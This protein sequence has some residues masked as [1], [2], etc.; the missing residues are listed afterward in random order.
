MSRPGS[1]I[2][3]MIPHRILH[4]L[5]DVH[6]LS[7]R[8]AQFIILAINDAMNAFESSLKVLYTVRSEDYHAEIASFE[9]VTLKSLTETTESLEKV[10]YTNTI[11]R[12]LNLEELRLQLQS[13]LRQRSRNL[14]L[15]ADRHDGESLFPVWTLLNELQMPFPVSSRGS[16]AI[17]FLIAFLTSAA[18]AVPT[19][20]I[21]STRSIGILQLVGQWTIADEDLI[22][23]PTL[24]ASHL[25][26]LKIE[27]PQ[28]G[29]KQRSLEFLKT[30]QQADEIN[31]TYAEAILEEEESAIDNNADIRG[32]E[33]DNTG[34]NGSSKAH[35]TRI[36]PGQSLISV[37][38]NYA[39]ENWIGYCQVNSN[40]EKWL[41]PKSNWISLRRRVIP[42]KDSESRTRQVQRIARRKADSSMAS[43]PVM[44]KGTL[45]T[46]CGSIDW[47]RGNSVVMSICRAQNSAIS[48]N[49]DDIELIGRSTGF[50]GIESREKVLFKLLKLVKQV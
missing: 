37:M 29:K 1:C 28:M 17:E 36:L 49:G 9:P 44:L 43:E 2:Q 42:S 3:A 24:Y 45:L 39:V 14:D 33:K 4:K 10:P 16:S 15:S 21:V 22:Q 47:T 35:Q 48:S 32:D 26:T 12:C 5:E 18:I 40:T 19:S 31:E 34:A 38:V 11:G 25:R 13:V 27:R 41:H 23:L 30:I 7:G 20:S 50:E 8:P 46:V 6:L